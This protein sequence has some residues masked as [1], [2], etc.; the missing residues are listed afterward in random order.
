[1]RKSIKFII[2]VLIVVL[3][4][5]LL[6][7]CNSNKNDD[8]IVEISTASAGSN[9]NSLE[10]LIFTDI[11][12]DGTALDA[13]R[14]EMITTLVG[15]AKPELII[16]NGNMVNSKE[17]GK[18][19]RDFVQFMDGI[20]KPWAAVLGNLDIVGEVSKKE[21]VKILS[22]SKYGLF[23]PGYNESGNYIINIK[24]KS[25]KYL[26]SIVMLDSSTAYTE[27]QVE[28][29]KNSIMSIS[30][31]NSTTLGKNV[32]SYMFANTPI[33]EF[34]TYA[35]F[36]GNPEYDNSGIST[37]RQ[38]VTVYE[39]D[40]KWGEA[41]KKA[42]TKFVFAGRDLKNNFNIVYKDVK[43]QCLNTSFY[44]EESPISVIGGATMITFTS[45]SYPST[46]IYYYK[47]YKQQA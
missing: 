6:V 2:L 13:T 18:V 46:S 43:Y 21:M 1:M 3:A 5:G 26:S 30:D 19:M 42:G 47:N 20:K 36:L 15:K 7:G 35:E 40:V 44:S 45:S 16:I 39:P 9:D 11:C 38:E 28:W 23:V 17:N 37:K 4:V 41:I 8:Y 34:K 25:K 32:T 24:N 31:Q 33:N 27:G 29:Y 14:K 10:T 22:N 12:M